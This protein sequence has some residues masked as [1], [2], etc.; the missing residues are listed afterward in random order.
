MLK[1]LGSLRDLSQQSVEYC[2][3]DDKVVASRSTSHNGGRN[4]ERSS[5]T[6]QLL[7]HQYRIM[8]LEIIDA[9]EVFEKKTFSTEEVLELVR[10]LFVVPEA[11]AAP[12]ANP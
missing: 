1:M 3:H 5:L 8:A 7:L 12:S 9:L 2:Q 6:L 4:P 11:E 10:G